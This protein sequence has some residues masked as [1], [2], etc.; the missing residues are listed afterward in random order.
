[1]FIRGKG[2]GGSSAL[3]FLFWTRPQRE[4]L[5]GMYGF[6]HYNCVSQIV[7]SR[8]GTW[9]PGLELGTLLR[10]GEES[11]DVCCSFPLLQLG[12]RLP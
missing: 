3:N 6:L 9:K 12:L 10:S 2:L 7:H 8:G 4:E 11:R 1:M 5:D